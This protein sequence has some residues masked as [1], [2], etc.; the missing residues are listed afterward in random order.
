MT[1]I[2]LYRKEIIR[3]FSRKDDLEEMTAE[4]FVKAVKAEKDVSLELYF[5]KHHE[6]LIGNLI[7]DI[8]E[9]G[10]TR[11]N[12]HELINQ[13]FNEN[14]YS[15]LMALDG[16]ASLGDTQISYKLFDEEENELTGSGEIE[17]AAYEQFMQ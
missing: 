8:I 16:E 11:D 13:V 10:A 5:S 9:N 4:E 14:C 12:L 1:L 15:L 6:T 3:F 7:N 2:N 17:S